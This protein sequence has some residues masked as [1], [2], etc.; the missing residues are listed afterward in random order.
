MNLP[1]ALAS[2]TY[3]VNNQLTNWAGTTLNYDA[4]GKMT[5]E[6]L[7]SANNSVSFSGHP[8][9]SNLRVAIG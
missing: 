7:H 4:N 2:A 1:V 6:R 9:D 5:Y 8:H 3:S